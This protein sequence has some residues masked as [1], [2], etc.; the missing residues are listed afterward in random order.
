MEG[1]QF[2]DTALTYTIS[3]HCVKFIQ[4][5][6]CSSL[7]IF[8]Q[9]ITDGQTDKDKAATICFLKIYSH[10]T[11]GTKYHKDKLLCLSTTPTLKRNSGTDVFD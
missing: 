6:S 2:L 7:L 4:I 1:L 5:V 3:N 10:I 9:M 8:Q 11:R